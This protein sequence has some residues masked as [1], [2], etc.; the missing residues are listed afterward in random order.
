MAQG[1][2]FL[3]SHPLRFLLYRFDVSFLSTFSCTG[4]VNVSQDV[5]PTGDPSEE[6]FVS[7]EAG[8]LNS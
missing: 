2:E 5:I 8:T 6:A 7:S 4:N 3:H 1:Y